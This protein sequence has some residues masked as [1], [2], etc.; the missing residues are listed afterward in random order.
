MKQL[1]YT[2][3]YIGK[4]IDNDLDDILKNLYSTNFFEMQV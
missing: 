2:E 1:K 3:R 4:I